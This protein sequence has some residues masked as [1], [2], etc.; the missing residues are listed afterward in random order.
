MAE[1]GGKVVRG[2]RNIDHLACRS[3]IGGQ[4][5]ET[6]RDRVDCESRCSQIIIRDWQAGSRS[7]GKVELDATCANPTSERP[8]G[9]V[10]TKLPEIT[11]NFPGCKQLVSLG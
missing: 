5:E 2:V 3:R 8:S 9:S 6:L 7:A 11:R 10:C 4:S 1:S